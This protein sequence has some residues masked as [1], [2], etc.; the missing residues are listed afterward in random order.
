MQQ[1]PNLPQAVA[2]VRGSVA[3]PKLRGQVRFY[4]LQ[5]CVLVEASIHGLPS[6]ET[7]FFGFHIHTGDR[8]LG[9]DFSDTLGHYNPTETP[10]P[11]H[12]GDLPPLMSCHGDAYLAVKTSRFR[13]KDVL[14]RTVVIH[15][16]PDDFTTQPAGNACTKI[17]CG[18]IRSTNG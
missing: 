10:H 18:I 5:Q 17:A 8:C 4:Q 15:S 1:K 13:I 2:D 6:S 11:L 12:A 16:M 3:Y 7:G 14:R 9:A